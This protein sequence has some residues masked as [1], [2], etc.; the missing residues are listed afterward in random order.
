MYFC[1]YDSPVGRLC[2]TSD[3]DSLTGLYFRGEYSAD[4][5][6][7]PQSLPIFGETIR[8]LDCYFSGN[9]PDFCPALTYSGT[10]FRV[11]VWEMLRKIPYGETM[12]YGE[13]AKILAERRGISKMS[14]QAVGGAVHANP[15]SI[16]IPC[17]RVI[18]AGGKLVG[19]G[20]GIDKKIKLLEIE[21]CTSFVRPF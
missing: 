17:H 3:G 5:V 16:I 18:G 6:L 21:N 4:D 7:I 2:L 19:Y 20:G 12:T 14:A 13:I 11:S 9:V 1:F 15:I 8:W 10:D